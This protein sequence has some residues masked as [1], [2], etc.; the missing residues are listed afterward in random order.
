MCLW[1][2]LL[3]ASRIWGEGRRV[4][5]TQKGRSK[6]VDNKRRLGERGRDT[7]L[8]VIYRNCSSLCR[9]GQWVTEVSRAVL[10]FGIRD[11]EGG[12]VAMERA[13]AVL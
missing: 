8:E 10:T 13:A 3:P 9:S 1:Y 5:R 6:R 4:G 2:S 7:D 11:V 12:N